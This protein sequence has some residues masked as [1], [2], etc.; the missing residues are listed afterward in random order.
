MKFLPLKNGNR[1]LFG[2]R[3]QLY[4]YSAL[5][6][7]HKKNRRNLRRADSKSIYI[8]IQSSTL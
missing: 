6:G 2:S 3:F 1:N 5:K 8:L 4:G 7:K